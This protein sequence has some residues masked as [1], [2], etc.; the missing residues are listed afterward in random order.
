LF[1]SGFLDVAAVAACCW[2]RR[3]GWREPML[4]LILLLA[5]G[6]CSRSASTQQAGGWWSDAGIRSADYPCSIERRPAS[7]VTTEQFREKFDLQQPLILTNATAEWGVSTAVFSREALLGL[8]ADAHVLAG[9]SASI[10]KARGAGHSRLP[11]RSLVRNMG[12]PSSTQETPERYAF[13]NGEFLP[14]NPSLQKALR[15]PPLYPKDRGGSTFFALGAADTGVQ[16]HFHA[17]GWALQLFGRKRWFFFPP[18][19]TPQPTYPPSVPIAHWAETMLPKLKTK[20]LLQCVLSAGV[21]EPS[22]Q[23]SPRA[24]R[25]HYPDHSEPGLMVCAHQR[26]TSVLCAGCLRVG[27][28]LCARGMVSRDAQFGGQRGRCIAARWRWLAAGGDGGAEEVERALA[29]RWRRAVSGG[30]GDVR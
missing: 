21:T 10:P 1:P 25:A 12:R 8:G 15:W 3:G 20:Q 11:L 28:D 27:L 24:S 29:A 17:D 16:F 14:A 30:A 7:S 19:V 18:N 4:L 22:M 2:S 6:C 13:D 26:L 9:T 23:P 5:S